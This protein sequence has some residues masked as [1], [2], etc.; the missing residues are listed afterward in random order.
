MV[1]SKPEDKDIKSVQNSDEEMSSYDY[2]Y[3][4]ESEDD[5]LDMSALIAKRKLQAEKTRRKIRAHKSKFYMKRL[6]K[7]QLNEHICTYLNENRSRLRKEMIQYFSKYNC[8]YSLINL[9]EHVWYRVAYSEFEKMKCNH[10]GFY[11]ETKIAQKWGSTFLEILGANSDDY[12]IFIH[13]SLLQIQKRKT[14]WGRP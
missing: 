9:K 11:L 4:S 5:R 10:Y 6:L 12:S 14:N 1:S 7:Y 3:S 2:E 8:N 13:D